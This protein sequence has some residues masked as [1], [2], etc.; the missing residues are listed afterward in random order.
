MDP[1]KVLF[2]RSKT[3]MFKVKE[4]IDLINCSNSNLEQRFD[5][6]PQLNLKSPRGFVYERELN[7]CIEK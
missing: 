6:Y 4:A 7:N 5:Y 3:L 2:E 1:N